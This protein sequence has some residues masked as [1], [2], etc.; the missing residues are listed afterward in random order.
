[1]ALKPAH[2]SGRHTHTGERE[3]HRQLQ[4]RSRYGNCS[5]LTCFRLSCLSLSLG[6]SLIDCCC[7]N[8]LLSCMPNPM[9]PFAVLLPACHF[10][11]S[12]W[13]HAHLLHAC[14]CILLQR[15]RGTECRCTHTQTHKMQT[16]THT[17]AQS[18]LSQLT[19]RLGVHGSVTGR[20]VVAHWLIGPRPS[21]VTSSPLFL[22]LSLPLALLCFYHN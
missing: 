3:I 14:F 21:R 20:I 22:S 5:T 12:E 7:G 9:M 11:S 6:Q 13:P 1:M 15:H 10:I 17:H 8:I 2:Q 19:C 4:W 18:R 16:H